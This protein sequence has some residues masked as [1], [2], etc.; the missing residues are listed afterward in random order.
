MWVIK[1]VWI[2][3]QLF[4]FVSQLSAHTA[5]G[6]VFAFAGGGKSGQRSRRPYRSG[7][8]IAA[9]VW[10]AVVQACLDARSTKSAFE[11]ANA[12]LRALRRQVGVAALAVWAQF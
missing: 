7:G 4:G 3:W 5:I 2:T 6:V 12:R 8:E 1:A 10:A 9:T 11:A